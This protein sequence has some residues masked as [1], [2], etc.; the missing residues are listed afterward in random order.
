ML[1]TRSSAKG[2]LQ[3]PNFWRHN[4][5]SARRRAFHDGTVARSLARHVGDP[6]ETPKRAKWLSSSDPARVTKR[7]SSEEVRAEIVSAWRTYRSWYRVNFS[8]SLENSTDSVLQVTSILS[9]GRKI[10]IRPTSPRPDN[11]TACLVPAQPC[12]VARSL[13]ASTVARGLVKMVKRLREI[14]PRSGVHARFVVAGSMAH[15]IAI[16]WSF[17]PGLG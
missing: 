4:W 12:A 9:L 10:G 7:C 8:R 3:F 15:R 16:I 5:R 2:V 13:Q 1:R 6:P 17:H 14:A 11:H